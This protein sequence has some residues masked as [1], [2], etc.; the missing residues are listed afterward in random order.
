MCF[1]ILRPTPA[2]EPTYKPV[3]ILLEWLSDGTWWWHHILPAWLREPV[4]G[5]WWMQAVLYIYHNLKRCLVSCVHRPGVMFTFMLWKASFP[6]WCYL[7]D[8]PSWG[9]FLPANSQLLDAE[10]GIFLL[11][12]RNSW[13]YYK[14]RWIKKKKNLLVP[15]WRYGCQEQWV[16]PG[17]SK[18]N[19]ITKQT[20]CLT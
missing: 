7:T 16:A 19:T 20:N 2:K 15:T 18:T 6:S 17:P 12:N 14:L 11:L 8:R 9:L 13:F 4:K 1:S 5:S 3:R 10:L